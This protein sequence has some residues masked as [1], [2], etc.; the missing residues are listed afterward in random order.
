MTHRNSADPRRG[1][2]SETQR[3]EAITHAA[4][5]HDVFARICLPPGKW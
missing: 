4:V 3:S 1:W 2:D 5:A